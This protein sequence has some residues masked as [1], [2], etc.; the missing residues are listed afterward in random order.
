MDVKKHKQN[1]RV[2][3]V[4]VSL[5]LFLLIWFFSFA[6]HMLTFSFFNYVY[7][8]HEKKASGRQEYT[9]SIE[10]FGH[11]NAQKSKTKTKEK[12][13][14]QKEETPE[15][16]EEKNEEQEAPQQ[17]ENEKETTEV[18]EKAT[19]ETNLSSKTPSDATKKKNIADL[20]GLGGDSGGQKSSSSTQKVVKKITGQGKRSRKVYS[21]RSGKGRKKAVAQYGGSAASENS[22]ELGLEWLSKHQDY[23][24]KWNTVDFY[25]HSSKKECWG[26]GYKKYTPGA[27]A[28]A[29]LAFLGAGYTTRSGKYRLQLQKAEDYLISTQDANGYFGGQEMYN[30]STVLLALA[31]SYALTKRKKLKSVIRMG[32]AAAISAQQPMGGWTYAALPSQERNDTSITGWMVMALVSAKRAGFTVPQKTFDRVWNHFQRM[33]TRDGEVRYEDVGPHTLRSSKALIPV[34][35]LCSILM[36]KSNPYA[37]KQI[38]IMDNYPPKWSLRYTIDNSMYYWYH[39]TLSLFLTGGRSWYQ[40]N[41][42]MRDMLIANQIKVGKARGSWNPSG[43]WCSAGGR[44]YST[45]INILNLEIYYRYHP[46]FIGVD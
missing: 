27:T 11:L 38:R 22:V 46:N 40:W 30:H 10:N 28:L 44:I 34:G 3:M 12:S 8:S 41:A 1:S 26:R 13:T 9:I 32:I 20:L 14:A 24:G 31:E 17:Q 7:F 43:K 35:L 2:H 25:K 5:K 4:S 37:N 21:L 16:S 18:Q 15:K 23:D 39:G 42:H 45:A 29:Y 36:N 6:W 19:T 33:T